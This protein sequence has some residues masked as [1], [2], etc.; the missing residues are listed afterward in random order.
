MK[1]FQNLPKKQYSTEIGNLSLS[2]FYSFYEKRTAG[3]RTN[4][5]VVDNNTTLVEASLTVFDDTDSTWAFLFSN[6]KINPFDLLKTNS[7]NYITENENKTAFS[8][9]TTTSSSFYASGVTFTLPVGSIAA[10]FV[11]PSGASWEYTSVGNFN[12]DGPFALVEENNSYNTSLSTKYQGD[13]TGITLIQPNITNG[14]ITY[15]GK[16]DTYY[17][18]GNNTVTVDAIEYTKSTYKETANGKEILYRTSGGS[19]DS[20]SAPSKFDTQN[21]T[22][23]TTT[24]EEEVKND[25]KNLNSISPLDMS[26]SLSPIVTPKYSG[27]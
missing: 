10:R 23:Q 5:V 12:L 14:F 19:K 17:S 18:I 21:P 6:N 15:I 20:N 16:G 1:F 4:S 7:T 27:L 9:R 25:T 13:S 26:S 22:A 3:K 24:I 8:A 2:S 11:I